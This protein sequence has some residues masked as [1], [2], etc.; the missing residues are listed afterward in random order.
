MVE[1]SGADRAFIGT[2]LDE[3]FAAAA[4]ISS[5]LILNRFD[6]DSIFA[7]AGILGFGSTPFKLDVFATAAIFTSLD[8]L[9]DELVA[10]SLGL[11]AGA[12]T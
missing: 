6:A 3:V 7:F 11:Q 1:S 9:F 10:I 8:E 2:G 5:S 4:R 12:A